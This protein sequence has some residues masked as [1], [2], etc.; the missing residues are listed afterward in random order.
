MPRA[1]GGHT[2]KGQKSGEM[3]GEQAHALVPGD[4]PGR[5]RGRWGAREALL[6]PP[7]AGWTPPASQ[8]Y[9]TS[10]SSQTD[11]PPQ[12]LLCTQDLLLV[13]PLSTSFLPRGPPSCPPTPP[14][15]QME[16]SLSFPTLIERN[17]ALTGRTPLAALSLEAE[18]LDVRY[19]G[20]RGGKDGSQ[21]FG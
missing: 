19:P 14:F 11:P 15:L 21:V 17:L 16:R 3:Q 5:G 10:L 9:Y 18:I 13:C 2:G 6:G 1:K 8:S 12:P 20:K 7:G 4:R